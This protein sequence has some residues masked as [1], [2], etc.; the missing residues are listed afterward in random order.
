MERAEKQ[1]RKGERVLSE[2]GTEKEHIEMMEFQQKIQDE[3]EPPAED[4]MSPRKRLVIQI[5]SVA[6]F[7][8]LITVV[9][10]LSDFFANNL[11]E[12]FEGLFSG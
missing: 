11:K 5:I 6:L 12:F 4:N 2:K 3:Q 9:V 1:K 7:L 10:L 8:V